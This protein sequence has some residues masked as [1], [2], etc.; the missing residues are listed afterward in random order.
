MTTQIDPI[1]QFTEAYIKSLIWQEYTDKVVITFVAGNLRSFSYKLEEFIKSQNTI[2]EDL[3]WYGP[4]A[5]TKCDLDGKKETMIVKAGNGAPD[6]LE[7]DFVHDSQ[8]PNHIWK[9]HHCA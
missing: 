9:K 6:D 2:P 4:H 8:Y 1:E 5:C 3:V 7:F